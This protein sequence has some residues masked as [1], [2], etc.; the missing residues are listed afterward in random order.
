M[1]T[2]DLA[3]EFIRQ[4]KERY[5][6]VKVATLEGGASR[7]GEAHGPAFIFQGPHMREE[8]LNSPNPH[9]TDTIESLSDSMYHLGKVDI[10]ITSGQSVRLGKQV[11]F[12]I[13]I[14]TRRTSQTYSVHWDWLLDAYHDLE[15]DNDVTKFSEYNPGNTSDMLEGILGG[16]LLSMKSFVDWEF[17]L[18]SF[19]MTCVKQCMDTA[20]NT[21][22]VES[23]KFQPSPNMLIL[24][25]RLNSFIWL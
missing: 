23:T 12:L 18:L 2:I 4:L 13:S 24:Q 11:P 7:S 10:T 3:M 17:N 16:W 20:P 8:F 5:T 9:E 21:T 14:L 6:V 22:T 1:D 25:R 15:W 19:R